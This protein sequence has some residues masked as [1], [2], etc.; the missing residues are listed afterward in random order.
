MHILVVALFNAV[1]K[2][3]RESTLQEESKKRKSSKVADS[4][5]L[6]IQDEPNNV[7]NKEE[8]RITQSQSKGWKAVSDEQIPLVRGFLRLIIC[9]LY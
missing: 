8:K 9:T 4:N 3:K 7:A 1:A 6:I 2:A 5:S